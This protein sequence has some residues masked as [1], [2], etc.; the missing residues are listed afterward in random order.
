V[1]VGGKPAR[2]LGRWLGGGDAVPEVGEFDAV[3][4]GDG[5]GDAISA[6]KAAP[7]AP[8]MRSGMVMDM[9]FLPWAGAVG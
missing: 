8:P 2:W 7:V 3:E 5:V 6:T 1:I 4:E 9:T